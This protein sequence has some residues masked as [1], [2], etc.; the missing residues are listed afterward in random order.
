M[1]LAKHESDLARAKE[2]M[3][4]VLTPIRFDYLTQ[5][6][7]QIVQDCGRTLCSSVCV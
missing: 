4:G 2:V 3:P 1:A 5:T 6:R 7:L